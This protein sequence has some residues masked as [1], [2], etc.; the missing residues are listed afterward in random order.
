[1]LNEYCLENGGTIPVIHTA[2]VWHSKS[3]HMSWKGTLKSFISRSLSQGIEK[4]DMLDYESKRT[5]YIDGFALSRI[6][7]DFLTA[8]S[9][10]VRF[11]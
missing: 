2:A 6:F 3:E 9:V 10:Q 11:W 7:A 8:E 1:M 4:L 5:T